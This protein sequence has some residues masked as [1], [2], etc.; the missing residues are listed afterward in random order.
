[1]SKIWVNL[2]KIFDQVATDE[3]LDKRFLRDLFY[4]FELPLSIEEFLEPI[5]K[6]EMVVF[7]DF[8]LLFKS[9]KFTRLGL[10]KRVETDLFPVTIMKFGKNK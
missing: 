10:V 3:S 6:K 4:N 9:K 1:L 2:G 7:N 5:G 8:C